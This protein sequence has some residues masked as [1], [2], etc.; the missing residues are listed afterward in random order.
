MQKT[1]LLSAF[2]IGLVALLAGCTNYEA[3]TLP[4]VE[5]TGKVTLPDG[6]PVDGINIQF[7]ALSRGG[8]PSMAPITAGSFKTTLPPG[9]YSFYFS[10]GKNPANFRLIPAKYQDNN[11]EHKV[12]V[13]PTATTLEIALTK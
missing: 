1:V 7:F 11:A 5:V 13:N 8:A 10:E 2:V 9:D 6:K 3:K 12:T 4:P